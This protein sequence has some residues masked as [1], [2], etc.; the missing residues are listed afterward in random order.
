MIQLNRI[1]LKGPRRKKCKN[2]EKKISKFFLK[3]FSVKYSLCKFCGHLNGEKQETKS[4][5]NTL[6]VS[7]PG[8][9]N[10][11]KNYAKSFN[12]RVKNIYNDKVLFLKSVLKN[13]ITLLDIGTGA[14]HFL[15]ALENNNIYAKGIEPNKTLYKIGN[16]YL[17]KN[18]ILNKP[19]SDLKEIILGEKK[20]NC[21][22]LIGVL[23]HVEN[24]ND[25]LNFFKISKMK[26]L[27]ISVPLFSLTSF[28]EN[29]FKN[30]YP[31]H[32]SG[33]HTHLYTKKS[34]YYFAKKY[35]FRILCEWWFGVDVADLYRSLLASSS[36]LNKNIYHNQL[37]KYL[38]TVLNKLQNDLDKQKI[39]SEVHVVLSK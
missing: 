13:K 32:L 21:L 22:S 31:R 26:F 39:C 10:L 27:Y 37:N 14:G 2:C 24:P 35:N 1:Y 30:V 15:K 25:I 17:K 36:F 7:G 29:S 5:F 18:E 11:E 28:I 19:F 20:T 8:S 38:F 34:I 12:Q 3:T 9:K 16:N 23:E 4:F 33:G 6:Y